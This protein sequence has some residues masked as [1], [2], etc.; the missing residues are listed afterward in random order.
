[1]NFSFSHSL[2]LSLCSGQELVINHEGGYAAAIVG[3]MARH[4]LAFRTEV[5]EQL[6]VLDPNLSMVDKQYVRILQR[7]K[8]LLRNS[9]NMDNVVSAF[10]P[11]CSTSKEAGHFRSFC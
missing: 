7:Y 11:V 9:G 4:R 6:V 5:P 1:M 8:E 2:S 10:S 3:L